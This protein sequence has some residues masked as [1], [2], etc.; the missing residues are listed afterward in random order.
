M[1]LKGLCDKPCFEFFRVPWP[2]HRKAEVS[3]NLGEVHSVWLPA[4]SVGLN[5]MYCNFQKS[6]YETLGIPHVQDNRMQT[7]SPSAPQKDWRQV[8]RVV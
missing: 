8:R 3:P 6:V 5:R 7:A 1:V 2:E 4:S